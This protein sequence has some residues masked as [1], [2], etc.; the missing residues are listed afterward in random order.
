M[1]WSALVVALSAAPAASAA[2]PDPQAVQQ[3]TTLFT[4]GSELYGKKQYAD[5]LAALQASH[6]LVP[7]PNSHLII[8]RCLREL[9][10]TVE[11]VAAFE[12]TGR[13]AAGEARYDETSKAAA[14]E[15]ADL[16]ATL[17]TVS[18]HVAHLPAGGQVLVDGAPVTLEADRSKGLHAPGSVTVVV[19]APPAPDVVKTVTVQAGGTAD[20]DLDASPPPPPPKRPTV[21]L[22]ALGAAGGVGVVGL[23][24]A[25]GFGVSSRSTFNSLQSTCGM[26]CTSPDQQ[27]Q[28]SSGQTA[29]T[30]SNVSLGIG[31][32]GVA[33]AAVVGVVLWRR[34]HHQ[35]PSSAWV[36]PPQ[37][38][39]AS[40]S[41]TLGPGHAG[42]EGRF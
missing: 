27:N 19:H 14:S 39:G 6:K 42:L 2:P 33:A 18:V 23:A 22:A 28:I 11:A 13:E 37:A 3:A 16:R 20:L 21:L 31:L 24:M 10:R 36:L 4:K 9:G 30:A 32:V 17:G 7:S 40:V 25:I 5:A 38:P 15:G 1:C 8:A 12:D 34:G 41:V 26:R 35:A 29:Q